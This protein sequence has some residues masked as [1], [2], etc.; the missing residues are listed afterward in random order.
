MQNIVQVYDDSQI[1]DKIHAY[2]DEFICD[3]DITKL[4]TETKNDIT[5]FTNSLT[6]E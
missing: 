6:T 2:V 1:L 5:N 3:I 4:I